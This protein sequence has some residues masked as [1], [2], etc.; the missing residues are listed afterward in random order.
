MQMCQDFL[1]LL[2]QKTKSMRKNKLTL[3]VALMGLAIVSCSKKSAAPAVVET[4]KAEAAKVDVS[5]ATIAEGKSIYEASCAKCHKLFSPAKHTKEEWTGVLNRM[6]PKAR[7]NE[8]QK[9]L[10]Y[11]YL[12]NSL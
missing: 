2:L 9:N 6:A 7:I 12:T 1:F 8:Q 5:E 10:V 4:P 11:V 3:I